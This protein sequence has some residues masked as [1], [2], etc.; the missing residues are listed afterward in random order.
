MDFV[1]IW[2]QTTSFSFYN[3]DK[4]IFITKVESVYGAVQT[5]SLYNTNTFSLY[6]VKD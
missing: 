6:K 5:E 1:W 3:M 4:P 2:E